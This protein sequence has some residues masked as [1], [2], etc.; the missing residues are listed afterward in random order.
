MHLHY[1]PTHTFSFLTYHTITISIS[2]KYAKDCIALRCC[3]CVAIHL[4]YTSI[5]IFDMCVC[6][7]GNN[8]CKQQTEASKVKMKERGKS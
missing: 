7:F 3:T 4:V 5:R 1:L 2:Y 8:L 6:V